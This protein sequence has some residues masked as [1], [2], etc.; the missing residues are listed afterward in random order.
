M[1]SNFC[2][3]S[4]RFLAILLMGVVPSFAQ[5]NIDSPF[6]SP[7]TGRPA[8]L[9]DFP[10]GIVPLEPIRLP[11]V[12]KGDPAAH[13]A[14]AQGAYMDRLY[15]FYEPAIEPDGKGF[16]RVEITD[17]NHPRASH[18]GFTVLYLDESSNELLR[19]SVTVQTDPMPGKAVSQNYDHPP[20]FWA[21]IKT[22]VIMPS[23]IYD[24]DPGQVQTF[25]IWP[26]PEP[27]MKYLGL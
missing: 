7:E 16:I 19:F 27:V 26:L 9:E 10:H 25:P 11:F 1:I 24:A 20:E 23:F 6:M 13:F 14:V 2:R 18:V 15:W 21:K 3:F 4:A 5:N 12:M 8:N 22:V 17:G